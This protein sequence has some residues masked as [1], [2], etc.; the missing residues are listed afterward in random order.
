MKYI[1][2]SKFGGPEVLTVIEEETPKPGEGMLLVEVPPAGI[3]YADVLACS[4]HYPAITRAPF[5]LGCEIAG[6][7]REVGKHVEVF[8]VGDPV[9]ALT[10]TGGGYASHIL[11]P[12]ATAIPFPKQLGWKRILLAAAGDECHRAPILRKGLLG[13][14]WYRS[15]RRY[16]KY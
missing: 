3:N 4:G 2:A 14:C 7:V 5:A 8:K 9:A 15:S 12:A 13:W 11:I 1:E 6:V 16:R 10:L